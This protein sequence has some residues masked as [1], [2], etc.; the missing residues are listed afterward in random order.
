LNA[1]KDAPMKTHAS[2]LLLCG[3]PDAAARTRKRITIIYRRITLTFLALSLLLGPR[4]ALAQGPLLWQQTLNGTANFF[5]E[6]LSVAVDTQGNVLAAG[7]TD[8]TGTGR[9]FTVAKFARDGTLLWQQTLNGSANGDDEAYS[10][11][12]DNQ[13][14]VLAAGFTRNTDTDFEFTVAKFARDGTLLWEQALNGSANG[15]DEAF[16][17][18]VD[19]QGNVLAAGY[20]QNTGT[21]Y[22]FTVAKFARDGTL[23]WQQTLN[24]TANGF[25]AALSVAVDTQGNV[26]AAGYIE[27]TGTGPDFTV[28]KFARDGALLWEQTLNGSANFDDVAFSVAVDNQGNVLAAGKTWNTG[29]G[30]DFT[31]VKFARDGTLLWQQALNG[32]AND[33]FEEEALSVAVDTQGNVLA[34]GY[35]QNTGT[36]DDFT[37]AKF[38]GDGTL[39]WEQTLNGTANNFDQAS[40]VAVDTQGNVLAAGE[41]WNTGT[42]FDFTVA[43]FASDGTLLWQ[44]TLNATKGFEVARSVAVDNQGNVLAAGGTVNID[45][46]NDDFTVAK[47]DR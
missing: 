23:L 32:T 7:Y 24:G 2:R 8:N 28:A 20:T 9:D 16:S 43:K 27:N 25:D 46:G 29:T 13:G 45:S 31:V 21:G 33:I 19:N 26:L 6:A 39:L 5:D 35:T 44:Q 17:V 40:S 37:V 11:A 36:G 34:A 4:A 41:I 42:D 3:C 22:D 10:V 18:A 47:F 12:V 14:N 30:V 15:D 1:L 38:A